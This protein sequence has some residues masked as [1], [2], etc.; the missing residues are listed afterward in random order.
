MSSKPTVATKKRVLIV[1]AYLDDARRPTRRPTT[2]LKAMG[3]VVL[4]GAFARER[5]EVRLWDEQSSGPLEDPAVLGW[6]DMLVLTGL[7]AAFDR[8]LHLSAYARSR[9]PAVVVVAGGPAIRALP[10]FSRQFFDWCCHGD[11]EEM[12]DVVTTV[13]GADHADP[14]M[15]PRYDLAYWLK[16]FGHVESTRY[17][18]FACTFCSLTGERRKYVRYD[19][20]ALRRQ[21]EAG[22]RRRFLLFID[23]NFYGNDRQHFLARL[24]LIGDMH[25]QGWF[26]G[27]GALVTS[28]FFLREDNLELARAA[29]CEVLFC[30]LE[31]FDAGSLDR[32][33]KAQNKVLP[34]V[35]LIR[36]CLEHGILLVYGLIADVSSR[37][38]ASIRDELEFVTS[39]TEITLPSFVVL[40]IPFPG[41]PFF[42]DLAQ[43]GRLL[44]G[45][46][47]R[48]LDGTTL[49]L[50]PM[51]P[52][53]EVG[54]F[55]RDLQ[56]LRG[57]RRNVMRHAVGFAK[58]YRRTLNARQL[59]V[60]LARDMALSGLPSLVRAGAAPLRAVLGRRDLVR[61]HVSTTEKIDRL[62][63]PAFPVH[64][65]FRSWFEPTTI[66]DVQGRLVPELA[67]QL[68]GSSP[69]SKALRDVGA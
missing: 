17:C 47:L 23:N 3:P 59:L 38:L 28:D 31:S 16:S 69:Q 29:G 26:G 19:L 51:D 63:T 60:A 41:T 50:Q 68:L 10:D 30:G 62:Y 57:Y 27:F 24:E 21:I 36:N 2:V 8:F 40:P 35:E 58:R 55:V 52:I 34:Q 14:E 6:P 45:T 43:A 33:H 18:N 65:R 56:S 61:T 7:T 25:R 42:R 64:A 4:A 54:E 67:S 9:N 20:A 66:V 46:R 53:D 13:F 1:N 32:F 44:P 22:G 49:C 39:C 15:V 48:D 11:V 37:S 5:C 12:L